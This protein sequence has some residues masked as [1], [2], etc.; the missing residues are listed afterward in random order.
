MATTRTQLGLSRG[1]VGVAS[2]QP[3][4]G[5]PRAAPGASLAHPADG[6]E[7]M[8]PPGQR[9]AGLRQADGMPHNTQCARLTPRAVAGP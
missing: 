4:R 8:L 9:V 2:R 1:Y 5:L 7:G 3:P 6:R